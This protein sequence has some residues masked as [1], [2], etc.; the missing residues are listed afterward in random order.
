MSESSSCFLSSSSFK[1]YF[2]TLF[3]V[4]W[5][6]N[7]GYV[8]IGSCGNDDWAVSKAV[9]CTPVTMTMVV[10]VV[11]TL[12]G[13]SAEPP[14]TPCWYWR[15][16]SEF[17]EG[18]RQSRRLHPA[19]TGDPIRSLMRAVGRATDYTL[20]VLEIRFG[21]WWGLSAEPATTPCWYWRSD[22]EFDEGCRQSRRLH[23]DDNEDGEGAD[24]TLYHPNSAVR[25]ALAPLKWCWGR[26]WW[27]LRGW[28]GRRVSPGGLNL[29]P[30]SSFNGRRPHV[31]LVPSLRYHLFSTL[32]PIIFSIFA[33]TLLFATWLF[34]PFTRFNVVDVNNQHFAVSHDPNSTFSYPL[35]D[36]KGT[37]PP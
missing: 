12:K 11:E 6:S 30:S 15:S 5:L 9:D 34:P 35:Y 3:T 26:G 4:L 37:C 20:L 19:G 16:D 17:D 22:S 7:Q 32:I 18:C 8:V 24:C 10:R 23:P 29:P 13:P 21:V 2:E 33:L 36:L 25:R 14:T 31:S 28:W 27:C 1:G